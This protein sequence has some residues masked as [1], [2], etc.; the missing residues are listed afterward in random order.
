V[1]RRRDPTPRGAGCRWKA[2][3][4]TV[5][6]D[7]AASFVA[8]HL[9]GVRL[10][11]PHPINRTVGCP[12]V[13]QWVGWRNTAAGGRFMLHFVH[14]WGSPAGSPDEAE[15]A[16]QLCVGRDLA[17]GVF[18]AW[19]YNAISFS[20]ASLAPYIARFQAHSVPYLV[21]HWE[22]SGLVSAFVAIPGSVVALELR[23]TKGVEAEAL[24]RHRWDLC[25]SRAKPPPRKIPT[26]LEP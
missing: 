12:H 2:T 11:S 23:S 25:S 22:E 6:P 24:A 9:D 10:G 18:D 15:M 16:S 17:S 5:D 4:A 20:V 8:L 21:R 1:L 14:S 3:T 19:L 13:S 26:A 7:A